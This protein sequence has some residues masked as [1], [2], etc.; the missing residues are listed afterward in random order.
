MMVDFG[1]L[2]M[3]LA[4]SLLVSNVWH[5]SAKVRWASMVLGV[6]AMLLPL[7]HYPS[8]AM[9]ARGYCGDVSIVTL[10]VLLA[11]RLNIAKAQWRH[12]WFGLTALALVFYPLALGLGRFDPYQLGFSP[13]ILLAVLAVLTLCLLQRQYF[14]TAGLIVLAVVAWRLELKESVNLWDY[15]LDPLLAIVACGKTLKHFLCKS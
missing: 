12:L 14:F 8:L 10:G 7:G 1:L 11:W 13:L 5:C 9:Y 6:L 15:L 3:A 4:G 2:S